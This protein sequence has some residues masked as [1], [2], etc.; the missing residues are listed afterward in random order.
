ML[1]KSTTSDITASGDHNFIYTLGDW[2]LNTHTNQ[3]LQGN[4]IV[5]VE[6]RLIN[7]LVYF[8]NHRNE[9][10]T[11]DELLKTIWQNKVVND[12]SLAVAISHLRKALNDNPRTPKYIKTI[13]GVGYQFIFQLP[14][15]PFAPQTPSEVTPPKKYMT[16]LLSLAIIALSISIAFV[17]NHFLTFPF[18]K[19][20]APHNSSATDTDPSS[21]FMQAKTLLARD[22]KEDWRSAITL[23]RKAILNNQQSAQAYTGIADAKMKL[24]GEQIADPVNN[25]EIRSLLDKALELDPR[26]ARTHMLLGILLSLDIHTFQQAEKYFLA[27]IALNPNDDGS[28]FQYAHLL[29]IQKR[30]VEAREQVDLARKINPLAYINTQMIWVY[31]AEGKYTNAAHELERIAS[32]EQ[33]DDFFYATS[34]NVYFEAGNEQKTFENMQWFFAKANFS[35]E[36]IAILQQQFNAGGIKF[37]Y[38]WLLDNKETAD[39]GQYTPPISWARYAVAI[40]EKKLAIDY[41][42]QAFAK[43][44]HHTACAVADPRYAP[45]YDEERFKKL[46]EPLKSPLKK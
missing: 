16:G 12:D 21:P 2:T 26:L 10:L 45:L 35:Q 23:F 13:P 8:L 24:L 7:L 25:K 18:V 36:K 38:R 46:F 19:L 22:S 15:A 28:H 3:L 37:V 42:E 1:D 11:K 33:K 44:Q 14:T 34:Q 9:I 40:G 41:L 5:D 32:T 17:S 43:G 27:S 39:V 30:F 6:H 31:L 29:L 20:N 4:Q